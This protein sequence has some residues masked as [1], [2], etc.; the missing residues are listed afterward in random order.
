MQSDRPAVRAT[1]LGTG[2][3]TGVPVIGCTCRVC[4]STD[5]RNRRLRCSCF[6][7]A[8][9][10]NLLIDAGPDFRAQALRAGIQRVDAVLITHH[11]FDH[12]AG[13]DDL[14]PL[15]F[16]NKKPIPCF[17][18]ADSARTLSKM[19]WYIFEDGSYPGVSKLEL[20]EVSAPFEIASRYFP[21][22]SVVVTP[23]EAHHG[24][25]LVMGFRIGGFAYLT[26]TNRIPESSYEHMKNLDVLVLD[27]LRHEPHRSH[28]TIPQA[29]EVAHRIS[30]KKTFFTHMTHTVLYEDENA[31]LPAGMELGYDGLTIEI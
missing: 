27:A 12:V 23:V 7:E 30:A 6:V 4:T 1:L 20:R 24:K 10:V 13:L 3:S 9:G 16:G 22:R 5:P 31:V 15:F 19:F 17:T 11:H 25:M 26:D 29:I 14:R 21:D 28:F 8:N 2:T 18:S